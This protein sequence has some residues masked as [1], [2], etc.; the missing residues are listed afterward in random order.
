MDKVKDDIK[1]QGLMCT[2]LLH[3]GLCHRRPTSTPHKSWNKM[4]EKNKKKE[5][6]KER[7]REGK[8]EGRK[9]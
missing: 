5:G 9:G 3:G 2:T 8:K 1:E 7:M 6:W 4:K